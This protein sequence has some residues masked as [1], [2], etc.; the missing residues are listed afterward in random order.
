MFS[1]ISL[2]I[3]LDICLHPG[4]IRNGKTFVVNYGT[5]RYILSSN[6]SLSH[7]AS[8]QFECDPGLFIQVFIMTNKLFM[9]LLRL[10]ARW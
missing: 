10:Y 2:F 7:G 6:V 1:F 9:T 4:V 3:Y 5:S 8:L